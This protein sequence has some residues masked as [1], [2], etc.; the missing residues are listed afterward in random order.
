MKQFLLSLLLASGA[1][2]ASHDAYIDFLEKNPVPLGNSEGGEIEI[3][4]DPELM[5]QIKNKTGRPVGIVEQDKYWIWVNDAVRF[6]NGS[7][8]VYG[9]LLWRHAPDGHGGVAVLPLLPDGKIGLIKTYRHATRSWEYELPRG[10]TQKGETFE[11]A[12]KREL[13]EESGFILASL[14][15]LGAMVPD[16]GI[17]NTAVPVFLGV[18]ET[19]GDSALEDSEAISGVESFTLDEIRQGFIEGQIR[20]TPLRDPFLSFALF[21][22]QIRN[23]LP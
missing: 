21:Q 20:G 18:V 15:S 2:A 19:Q 11:E 9:R 22:A 4:L 16:S 3:L 7:T 17:S 13:Q 6:P 1:F 23:L 5:A 10:G 14:H 8:G 12:A